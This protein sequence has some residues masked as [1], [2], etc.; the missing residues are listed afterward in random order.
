LIERKL[1]KRGVAR[2]PNQP[3]SGWLERVTRESTLAP[4]KEPLQ[5]L[6]RLH[7]RCRFDPRGLNAEDRVELKRGTRVVLKSLEK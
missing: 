4:M 1:A 7:Y 3:L 2:Q 5:A 6:L